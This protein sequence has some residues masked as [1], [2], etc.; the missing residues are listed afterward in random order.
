M[1]YN[2]NDYSPTYGGVINSSGNV[3]NVADTLDEATGQFKPQAN[4][5]FT[6]QTNATALGTGTTATVTGYNSIAVTCTSTG[7]AV[8]TFEYSPDNTNWFALAGQQA[9]QTT[10]SITLQSTLT[11][12]S[13]HSIRF[14][15]QDF[16]YIRCRIT[17]YTSGTI[18][19][20]GDASTSVFVP[21]LGAVSAYG[22]TDA[23]S[24]SN[25]LLGAGGYNL[26]Y[27]G[28][29]WARQRGM[30]AIADASTGVG[31]V[32][33]GLVAFNGTTY[34]RIRT[35][36][37]A[38]D[39]N[40]GTGILATALVAYNGSTWDRVRTSEAIADATVGKFLATG[41]WGYNG[42]TFD[43][44]R[45]GKVYKYIEYLNLPTS[46]ATTIW[47]PTTGKKFRLMGVI[48]STSAT[49][50][51]HLRD[52]AGGTIFFTSRTLATGQTFDFGNGYLSAAA[53]NVLEVRNDSGTTTNVWITAWGTEE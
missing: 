36:V 50:H 28:T 42:A 14:N 20:F 53:N 4:K 40:A 41:L 47:T 23:N 46:T 38:A 18:N 52:G 8:I 49:V 10:T 9:N 31:V 6:F 17:T 37:G 19:V 1:P 2:I 44:A 29:N 34:D 12:T 32:S 21:L 11:V 30:Q 3:V 22:S 39:A 13:T 51:L 15:I 24:A 43:R 7:S 16:D 25:S 35:V 27:D 45:V 48:V 5:T 26:I 33:N